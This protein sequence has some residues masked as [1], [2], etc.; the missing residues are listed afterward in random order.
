[1]GG[2]GSQNWNPPI[3]NDFPLHD[4]LWYRWGYYNLL[5]SNSCSHICCNI[6]LLTFLWPCACV[7]YCLVIISFVSCK[8]AE[9]LLQN[10]DYYQYLILLHNN[11]LGTHS[12]II[13]CT[14]GHIIIMSIVCIVLPHD[15]VSVCMTT[16]VI[17]KTLVYNLLSCERLFSNVTL[18]KKKYLVTWYI[19]RIGHVTYPWQTND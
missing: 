2:G 8:L 1:M 15:C 7:L 6:S 19:D 10:W 14:E 16:L 11:T 3:E 5:D 12:S 4:P 17:C 18:F 9:S 13:Q